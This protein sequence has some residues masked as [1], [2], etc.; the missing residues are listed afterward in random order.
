MPLNLSWKQFKDLLDIIIKHNVAGVTVANLQKDRNKLDLK[1][2]LPDEV[3]GSFSGKPSW[4]ASNELIRKTYLCYGEKLTIIGV[5]GIFNA[6]EAY[7]KIRLG[8]SLVQIITGMLFNGPQLAAEISY[9]LSKLL[10][11]DGFSS[12]SDAV[13]V[14][15]K[16]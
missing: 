6:E 15:A 7:T 3:R 8:A 2:P 14:D 10:K 1:D 4:E 5:G 12:I 13:G 9:D 16:H 11:R